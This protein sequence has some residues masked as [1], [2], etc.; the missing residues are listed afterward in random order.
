MSGRQRAAVALFAL[1]PEDR[2]LILAELQPQEQA[3]LRGQLREM[4]EL[5]FERGAMP[6][7]QTAAPSAGGNEDALARASAAALFAILENEPAALVAEVLALREWPC[8]DALLALFPAGRRNAIS[9]AAVNVAANGSAPA[10][11]R[12]LEQELRGRLAESGAIDNVPAMGW[13]AWLQK[14]AAWKP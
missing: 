11:R 2:E 8:R 1:M 5:G 10:R 13:R 3:L 7:L 4:Q 6:W 14:V 9:I 12:W